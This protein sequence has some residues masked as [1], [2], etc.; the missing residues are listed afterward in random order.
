[1]MF[2]SFDES[3]RIVR[4]F[5]HGRVVIPSDLAWSEAY[6][7]YAHYPGARQIIFLDVERVGTSCGYGV[8]QMALVATRDILPPKRAART[9]WY[10]SPTNLASID[11]LPTHL[12]PAENVPRG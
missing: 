8:P 9:D 6:A 12:Q 5:G 1:M 3:P 7:P 11:G 2:C 4:L 10:C